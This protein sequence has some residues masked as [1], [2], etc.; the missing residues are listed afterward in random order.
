MARVALQVAA[1]AWTLAACREA[2]SYID[3][4]R[5]AQAGQASSGRA[6]RLFAA[7]L[8]AGEPLPADVTAD[9][10]Q[11]GWFCLDLPDRPRPRLLP[12][13]GDGRIRVVQGD[14][15]GGWEVAAIDLASRSATHETAF[16][17][18]HDGLAAFGVVGRVGP[19][20][21]PTPAVAP[22]PDGLFP[23]PEA[24]TPVAWLVWRTAQ[25]ERTLAADATHVTSFG[26]D[27]AGH[28][29]AF[30]D[31]PPDATP[32]LW[33]LALAGEAT[34]L[35]VGVAHQVWSLIGD[36][37]TALVRGPGSEGL[38]TQWISLPDGTTRAIGPDADAVAAVDRGV[39][40]QTRDGRLL[41]VDIDTGVQHMLRGAPGQGNLLTGGG[42]PAV[43][44]PEDA[45]ETTLFW[46]D[47]RGLRRVTRMG[48]A[49]WRAALPMQG[50]VVAA[51]VGW[52]PREGRSFD[53]L[54][55]PARVCVVAR[56]VGS[57]RVGPVA[58]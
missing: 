38:E 36:G 2:P 44:V 22:Q 25:G 46:F 42:Q 39:V 12:A 40:I 24:A 30:V 5:Y 53:P 26:L 14:G 10:L 34:P 29:L 35:Q 37:T 21:E 41:Q 18:A 7:A 57:L 11:L 20:A 4:S 50:A 9:A 8:P 13:R 45:S 43:A 27:D 23:L 33:A 58:P 19:A 55:D 48:P 16:A 32:T 3:P 31:A 56:A 47:G 52:P 6:P 51:L 17:T 28:I 49:L 15:Q 1:V 54:A